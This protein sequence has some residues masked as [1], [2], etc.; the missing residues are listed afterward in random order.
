MQSFCFFVPTKE[1]WALGAS[2][3]NNKHIKSKEKTYE[4]I[5][6]NEEL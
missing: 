5:L 1:V 4:K 2:P 3:Q 6:N